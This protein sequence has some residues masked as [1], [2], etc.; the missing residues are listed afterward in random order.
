MGVDVWVWVCI[1]EV[2]EYFWT[3]VKLQE[4]VCAIFS[5]QVLFGKIN[6]ILSLGRGPSAESIIYISAKVFSKSSFLVRNERAKNVLVLTLKR[7]ALLF[8]L[9]AAIYSH[10]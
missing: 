8:S 9:L 1:G 4:F 10:P 6:F 3:F 2:K 7:V 5:M